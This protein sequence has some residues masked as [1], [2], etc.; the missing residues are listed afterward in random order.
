MEKYIGRKIKLLCSNNGGEYISD[1][2]LQI[3]C[4]EGIESHFTVREILQQNEVAERM[5]HTSLEKV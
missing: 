4:D 2:F 5:N 1:P 3:C